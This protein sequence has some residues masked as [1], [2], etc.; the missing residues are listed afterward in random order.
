MLY[1]IFHLSQ[2]IDKWFLS[3]IGRALQKAAAAAAINRAWRARMAGGEPTKGGGKGKGTEEREE[4]CL[5]V[6]CV[7]L[8]VATN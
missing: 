1:K 7:S 6:S 2:T 8:F 3:Q 4:E 5:E